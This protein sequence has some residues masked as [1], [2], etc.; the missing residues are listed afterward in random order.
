MT[1]IQR[2]MQFQRPQKRIFDSQ[3]TSYFQH[4]VA[5]HRIRHYLKRYIMCMTGIPIPATDYKPYYE[6]SRRI[7]ALIDNLF[8]LF[9]ETPPLQGPRR[10][11]NLADRT[12]HD[13]KHDT[14]RGLIEKIVDGTNAQKYIED[15]NGLLDEL[16]Y[17]IEN[18][19]GSKIRLDF[20]TGHELSF[21][22]FISSLDYLQLWD[23]EE[24]TPIDQN[25]FSTDLIFIWNKYY[26]LVRSLIL[27]YNLEPAGSHGVW[28][29]D[30][31]FHL[32]YIWGASQWCE[33][34]DIIAP[35]DL[36]SKQQYD[37]YKDKNFFSQTISFII[38][39]KTGP[40]REHS[41]ILNDIL[42]TVRSWKKIQRGL[43]RMYDDEVL[44][45]F[46]VVQHFWFGS[47]F[48]PWVDIKSGK[49]LPTFEGGGPESQKQ[50]QDEKEARHLN[51]FGSTATISNRATATST[52]THLPT[53]NTFSTTTSMPSPISIARTMGPPS[54]R[55]VNRFL[56]MDPARDRLRRRE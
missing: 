17:Y 7:V 40:F 24:E 45:K 28:G 33:Q 31:F 26:H 14:I 6:T 13:K 29:L 55:N 52:A 48:F 53:T 12:W 41:P 42:T 23:S 15:Q 18:A 30:D 32:A 20:G 10:Y 36:V 19:F 1:T 8:K 21:L 38:H 9:Q 22:A 56:P 46:P 35:R 43:L 34:E 44:N 39:V 50:Q 37:F 5:I 16:Q 27:T 4:S 47:G 3:T 25:K 54:I 11:G 2:T 51:S 49:V